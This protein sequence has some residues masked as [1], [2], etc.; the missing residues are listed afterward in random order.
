[1]K[2]FELLLSCSETKQV[3]LLVLKDS[4]QTRHLPGLIIRHCRSVG[5]MGTKGLSFLSAGK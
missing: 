4:D 5:S 3:N 2:V 1:M